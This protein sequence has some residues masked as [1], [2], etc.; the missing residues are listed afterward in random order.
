[1][2]VMHTPRPIKETDLP[3]RIPDLICRATSHITRKENENMPEASTPLNC[4]PA[5][6]NMATPTKAPEPEAMDKPEVRRDPLIP[7]HS[8]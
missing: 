7:I 8:K 4:L 5:M 6:K 3:K 2:I 1:M